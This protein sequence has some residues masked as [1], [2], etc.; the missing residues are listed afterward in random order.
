MNLPEKHFE[1]PFKITATRSWPIVIGR[2]LS[3]RLNNFIDLKAYSSLVLVTDQITERLYGEAVGAVLEQTGKKVFRLTLG[4]GESAKSFERLDEGYRFLLESGIDRNALMVVLGGGVVGDIAGYL[5]A[6]YLRGI[7]YIQLPTTL[8]AQVDSAIGGKVGVNFGGKKNM[9]GS[10]Y[11]PKAIISDIDFLKSLPPAEIRNGLAEVVKYGL[12]MD[13]DLFERLDRK[14]DA[15]LKPSE[16]VPII[17][18]C[19]ALKAGVVMADETERTGERAILNFGHTIAHA[20]EAACGLEG[21]HGAAV[22]I[23]MV[24]ASKI[25]ARLGM[26]AGD[27]PP[28]IE[29][30]LAKFGLPTRS[31]LVSPPELLANIKFDKK[32]SMGEPRWVLLAEL[33]RSVVNCKVPEAVVSQA[34]SEVCR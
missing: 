30:A 3:N 13:K 10:F 12:S 28:R 9:V 23:G 6:S 29:A 1:I 25:S 33:G 32:A 18:R 8:L 21:Q 24:A 7:D 17:E 20:L 5:A 26:L 34:L 27:C 22:S 11:Q 2:G 19:S 31:P 16:L 4:T 14:K 15:E